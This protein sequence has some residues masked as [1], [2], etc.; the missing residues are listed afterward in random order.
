[1]TRMKRADR[2]RPQ[3]FVSG[4][5]LLM[6]LTGEAYP[7]DAAKGKTIRDISLISEVPA[8]RREH[9]KPDRVVGGVPAAEGAWP[10]QVAL[11]N[12]EGL[13]EGADTQY[14]AQFCGGTLIA[15][16]WVLTAAHCVVHGGNVT[17]PDAIVVLT[18]ATKLTDGKRNPV[19]R[20]VSH[21]G[22][23]DTTMQNDI[24]LLQLSAPADAPAVRLGTPQVGHDATVIG[25]GMLEDE[26]YPV[27]LMEATV[28]I[29]EV[30]ACNDGI[31]G[32]RRADIR[33]ALD[34]I[35][36]AF[37]V[38]ESDIAE[39]ADILAARIKDPLAD[40]MLCAGLQSGE[41][42]SCYG[43]SGGPLLVSDAGAIAQ[44]GVVSWGSGPMDASNVCGHP[45]AYAVYTDVTAYSD[46]INST[47]Q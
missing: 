8:S 43:D 47:L 45:N 44:V 36:T 11:L 40:G 14:D 38:L 2:L 5:C 3:A 25:W 27:D 32:Y 42:D 7:A 6:L 41:R 18:G 35:G 46:W 30:A 37:G 24:A 19:S 22:Y 31:K 33:S 34:Q 29:Q 16:D 9:G 10:F 13:G 12:A 15:P 21:P 23:D 26:T 17:Q 28:Q 20:I 39:I 1:M 4:M